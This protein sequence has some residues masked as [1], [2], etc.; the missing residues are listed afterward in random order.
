MIY[1]EKISLLNR[2][3]SL[4]KDF[5]ETIPPGLVKEKPSDIAFSINEIIY[6]LLEVEEL[7]QRRIHQLLHEDHPHFQQINPDELAKTNRYNEQNYDEGIAQ[8]QASREDTISLISEMT[9]EELLR[10]G[11]HSRYGEMDTFRI[12]DIMADHDLQHLRQMERTLKQ[13][14]N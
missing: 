14:K 1:P 10:K 7:W 6:H 12:V 8:W 2:T 13:I 9:D 4:V 3:H 5:A 11:V